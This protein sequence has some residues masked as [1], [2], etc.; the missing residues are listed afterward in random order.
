VFLSML[1]HV[2]LS[3]ACCSPAQFEGLE[4]VS[5]GQDINGTTSAAEVCLSYLCMYSC[6]NG[7][8]KDKSNNN[9]GHFIIT[10]L[11]STDMSSLY[12]CID[13]M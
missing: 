8:I 1:L 9:W 4:G 11:C 2:H 3:D 5:S 6:D 7:E 10:I 12:P 13:G